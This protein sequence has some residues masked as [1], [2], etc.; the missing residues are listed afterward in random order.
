M[1]ID[2]SP[3]DTARF[4]VRSAKGFIRQ[5]SEIDAA[6]DFSRE[7]GVRFLIVRCATEDT[8]I[9]Q[10]L[11]KSGMFLTDTLVFFSLPLREWTAPAPAREMAIRR[12]QPD[13]V[14]VVGRIAAESFRGYAGHYHADPRLDR[15]QCDAVYVDWSRK[16]CAPANH[17]QT[18]LLATI[19]GKA[20]G[21]MAF[22]RR[23][24][25]EGEAVLGGVVTS[26]R[27]RGVYQALLTAGLVWLREQGASTAIVST[28]ITNTAVQKVWTRLGFE[29]HRA[30]YTFHGWF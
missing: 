19:D 2:W 15:N 24:G 23:D 26:A 4:G 16:L 22:R 12:L 28:Q 17:P 9:V 14:D 8:E 25:D 21:Y 10:R 5:T 11:Q 13:E 7:N 3:E 27:K 18:V 1:P 30:V 6:L 20:A 29:P